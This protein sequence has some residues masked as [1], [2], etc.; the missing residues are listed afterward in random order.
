[1]ANYYSKDFNYEEWSVKA[2]EYYESKAEKVETETLPLE[3]RTY[4]NVW[5]SFYTDQG[6][7]A[8]Q[9][10][11]F[12]ETEFKGFLGDSSEGSLSIDIGA[13]VGSCS[14][15]LLES[16]GEKITSYMHIDCSEIA[17]RHLKDKIDELVSRG[18]V[19]VDNNKM[20]GYSKWDITTSPWTG[21]LSFNVGLCIFTLSALHPDSHENALRNIKSS[22]SANAVICFRDYALHDMTQYRHSVV[23]SDSTFCPMP[24]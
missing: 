16:L 22:L 24:A 4:G 5:D 10:R 13:G 1:M 3:D 20:I 7:N 11:R 8:Y 2:P 18:D 23:V 19:Q 14:L 17:L 21:T 12:I 9:K 6:S 15:S